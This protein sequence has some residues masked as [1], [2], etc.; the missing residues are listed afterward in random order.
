MRQGIPAY[1]LP[2]AVLEAEIARLVDLGVQMRCHEALTE[3]A[4]FERLRAAHD[5]VFVATGAARIRRLA[6]LDYRLAGVMDGAA[7]L[8]ACNAGTP[9]ALGPDVVVIGGGS[10]ALDAA[11]RARRRGHTV[12]VL[13][14]E[15]RAQMPAQREEVDEAVEE[16]NHSPGLGGVLHQEL[17]AALYGAPG[18]PRV[19]G[20]LA[21]VGGVNVPP[22]RIAAFVREAV[23]GEPQAESVWVR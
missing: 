20:L 3:P 1:R 21:G 16:G 9:P 17:R 10:A 11:R 18:A 2:R 7:Y 8:C 19:H 13:A 23:A 14:L 5:A 6:A 12:S 22:R 4:Q 15:S